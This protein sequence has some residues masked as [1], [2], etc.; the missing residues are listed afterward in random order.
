M[1]AETANALVL[2]IAAWLIVSVVSL[3]VLS[4]ITIRILDTYRAVL[5]VRQRVDM[6]ER[7]GEN[8]ETT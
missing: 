3:V 6:L 5:D 2:V 4:L 8:E 7:H 1:S